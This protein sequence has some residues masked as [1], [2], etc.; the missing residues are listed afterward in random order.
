MEAARGF[1]G[2]PEPTSGS[3]AGGEQ[4]TRGD[5]G[6]FFA[7]RV[8][9]TPH[10]ARIGDYNPEMPEPNGRETVRLWP[11]GPADESTLT[12]FPLDPAADCHGHVLVLPGGGYQGLADHEGPTIAERLNAAGFDASV[13]RYRLGSAGH[14]HPDMLHDAQRAMRLVRQRLEADGVP[15]RRVAVL[16]FSAGGHLA[17]TLAVHH[18]APPG[19]ADDLVGDYPARP[20]AAVLCYAVIDMA[21]PA[22]HAGSRTALL[23]EQREG[24]VALRERLSTHRHVTAQ[25]PPT[26]LW[27]TA[28]DAG[29]PVANCLMFANACAEHGVPVELH[30]YESG[31]HGLGLA[32]D[33][34]SVA[35]WIDHATDFL[36]RHLG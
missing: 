2:R 8:R 13:L 30:V 6:L 33:N 34:P 28:D 21:G 5:V 15:G 36:Q 3:G 20:D 12:F 18:D 31:P 23:G 27:H 26:F 14:R 22:A 17:S 9:A 32:P 4:P 11:D 16:G 24:D 35:T 25:T 1:W 10:P 7:R 19:E 29:V